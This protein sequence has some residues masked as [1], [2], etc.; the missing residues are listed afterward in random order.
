MSLFV[1]PRKVRLRL[2]TIQKPYLV[3]WSIVFSDKKKKGGLVWA[4]EVS[5][6]NW[7]LLGKRNWRYVSDGE[8]FWKQIMEEK[9]RK[10][11][12]GW[13]PCEVRDAYGWCLESY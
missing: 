7:A 9:Y 12:A 3:S 1:I 13:H 4:L 8:G 5:L 6:L 2:E 10:E 11:G